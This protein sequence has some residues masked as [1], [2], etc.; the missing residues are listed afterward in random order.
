MADSELKSFFAPLDA[1][2]KASAVTRIADACHVSRTTVYRWIEA[3][4]VTKYLY[5]QAINEEF[6]KEIFKL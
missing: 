4:R 2:H 5:K 6:R 1:A 3:G